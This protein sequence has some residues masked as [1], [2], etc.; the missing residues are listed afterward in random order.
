M[1]TADNENYQGWKF[2]LQNLKLSCKHLCSKPINQLYQPYNLFTFISDRDKG[3]IEA[4]K[5]VFPENHH[6]NCQVHIRRNVMTRYGKQAAALIPKIGMTFSSRVEGYWLSKLQEKSPLAYDYIEGIDPNTWRCAT[7]MTF[8][9]LPPRY[10]IT[11]SNISESV[12]KMFDKARNVNWLD[13]LDMMLDIISTR[14]CN[15]RNEYKDRTGVIVRVEQQLRLLYNS[16]ASFRVLAIEDDNDN[17]SVAPQKGN[18][19]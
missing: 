5:E 7:W 18:D 13:C 1:I 4:C 16:S 19:S 17:F 6:T 3:L 12:N 2:F 10:G 11:S 14:I 15:L 9:N 8:T